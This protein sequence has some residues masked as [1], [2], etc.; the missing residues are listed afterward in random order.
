MEVALVI[1]DH[2]EAEAIVVTVEGDIQEGTEDT[3]GITK[4]LRE[5]LLQLLSL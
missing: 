3:G 5:T 4:Y 2:P 1:Q